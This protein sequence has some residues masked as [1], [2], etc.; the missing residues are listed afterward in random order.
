MDFKKHIRGVPDFPKP[1][2]LFYDIGT[3]LANGPVWRQAV[4][5]M[6]ERVRPLQP[7]VLIGIESRGFLVA[8]PLAAALNI[9]FVMARK[10]GKLPGK[11][12]PHTYDLEYGS[13]TI[14]IQEGMLAPGQRAV[15]CDDLLA[16][17]GTCA[18]AIHLARKIGADVIHAAFVIELAFLN[19]RSKLGVP[20]TS[21][22]SYDE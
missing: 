16:T 10:K 15:I 3:L 4:D 14:E 22:I 20:C 9:G 7:E 13:D 19:G 18:A 11:T 2:I 1:G 8:A 21:L 17:G 6:V 12:I 5:Q